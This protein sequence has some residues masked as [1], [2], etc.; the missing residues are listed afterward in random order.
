MSNRTPEEKKRARMWHAQTN[1]TKAQM[2][3][4]S[5]ELYKEVLQLRDRVNN[6]TIALEDYANEENWKVDYVHVRCGVDPVWVWEGQVHPDDD[7]ADPG[8]IAREALAS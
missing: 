7:D 5:S 2:E 1:M 4:W 3:E 6:L 8:W